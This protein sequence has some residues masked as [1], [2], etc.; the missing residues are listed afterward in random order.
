MSNKT[1]KFWH[2][3]GIHNLPKKDLERVPKPK[4][5][6]SGTTT[7]VKGADKGEPK[8]KGKGKKG[9]GKK[10]KGKGDGTSPNKLTDEEKQ[11]RLKSNPPPPEGGWQDMMTFNGLKTKY[12]LCQRCLGGKECK[13]YNKDNNKILMHSGHLK[14]HE[15]AAEVKRSQWQNYDAH[16]GKKQ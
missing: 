10:G 8:G 7:P 11:K 2:T 3:K 4:G 13:E 12:E 9:D 16:M 6:K 1:C 14:S 15:F 5:F